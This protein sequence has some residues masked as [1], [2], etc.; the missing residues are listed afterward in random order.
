ML[1]GFGV[2]EKGN[3]VARVALFRI[4]DLGSVVFGKSGIAFGCPNIPSVN[5][6]PCIKGKSGNQR[7][8]GLTVGAIGPDKHQQ[9]IHRVIIAESPKRRYARFGVSFFFSRKKPIAMLL[10]TDLIVA[11]SR[12]GKKNLPGASSQPLS[13]TFRV[14]RDTPFDRILTKSPVGKGY[15]PFRLTLK[16]EDDSITFRIPPVRMNTEFLYQLAVRK[17]LSIEEGGVDR[18]NR[19]MRLHWAAPYAHPYYGFWVKLIFD[20]NGITG[21]YTIS[22]TGTWCLQNWYHHLATSRGIVKK[23]VQRVRK[24]K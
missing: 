20:P 24:I 17:R 2:V 5:F 10:L 9:I 19:I 6:K 14:S 8:H 7:L 16:Y 22:V 13:G 3:S 21:T 11:A 18:R 1:A 12:C 15:P 4:G 23:R